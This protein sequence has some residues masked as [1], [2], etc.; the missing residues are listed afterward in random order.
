MRM[1]QLLFKENSWGYFKDAVNKFAK[2]NYVDCE[3]NE[4]ILL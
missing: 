4:A 1:K 3:A 2:W